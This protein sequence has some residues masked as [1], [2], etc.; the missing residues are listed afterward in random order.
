MLLFLFAPKK[1]I[2]T[3]TQVIVNTVKAFSKPRYTAFYF[4]TSIAAM[5]NEM[6]A[7][8]IHSS[9]CSR[10]YQ[11]KKKKKYLV[12]AGQNCMCVRIDCHHRL[13]WLFIYFNF[14]YNSVNLQRKEIMW[15]T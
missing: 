9:L 10:E 11:K 3:N 13:Y 5:M 2:D 1:W 14:K 7:K 4:K 6:V 15:L 12:F 8:K